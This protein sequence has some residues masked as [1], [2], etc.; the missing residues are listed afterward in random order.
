[1]RFTPNLPTNGYYDVYVWWVYA[2]NR[3]TNTPMD[4]AG[5]SNFST[6]Y[7][8]QTINCTNWVKIAAS[9]YFNAGTNGYVTIRN[10]G[11]TNYVVANAV[12]FMPLGGIAPPPSNPPP[13]IAIVASDAQAGEFGTNTGRFCVVSLNGTNSAPVTVNYSVGGTAIPGTDYAALPGSVVIPAGSLVADV[14]VS[15]LG[16]NLLTDSVAVTLSLSAST[17]YAVTNPANATVTILDRPLNAWRRANFTTAEL[18]NP[19][20]SGDN[21]DPDGDGISNLMEY[22]M[23]LPPKVA[24]ANPLNPQIVNGNFTIT[25]SRSK[26]A[27]DVATTLQSSTDLVNWQSGP[28]YFQQVNTVDQVTNQLITAQTTVPVNVSSKTYVRLVVTKL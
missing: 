18:A 23:G 7:I 17:N 5:A 4:V 24:N 8:D 3:A 28:S 10:G 15:P 11:T 14:P 6:V 22:A 1:V 26:G 21:A 19:Q 12:R 25:Y 9:N 16:S 27:T 20:I 2:S 13:A